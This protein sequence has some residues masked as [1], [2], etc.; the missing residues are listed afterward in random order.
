MKVLGTQFTPNASRKERDVRQNIRPS[1]REFVRTGAAGAALML[2][3]AKLAAA[4]SGKLPQRSFGKTGV[5]VSI[6]GLGT[7]SLGNLSEKKDAEALLNK[8]IDL[9]INYIDT[10]PSATS[11]ATFTGYGKAQRY[12][13]SILKE[14]RAEVFVV[15]KC[16]ETERDKALELLK[17]SLKELG[18]E[19]ADLVHSHSIGHA[20]Y[21][22]DALVGD[23]GTMA[24]LEQARKDGLTRF[25]GI[26]GHNRPEKF[27]KVLEKRKIDGMMNAINIVDRH[28][29][30]FE[31]VV[32]PT[33]RKQQ[34]A[35]AAM[36]VYG[37]G[38]VA[39]KMPEELRRA[40]L[41][42]ALGVEGVAVAVLGMRTIQE[43]EQN[44]EWAKSFEPLKRAELADLKKKTVEL[45]KQ[46]GAH[47]DRLDSNGEKTRPLVNA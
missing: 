8:A 30:A 5:K 46:W 10:A 28:T 32:W 17:K 6:I 14:R 15:T 43:L 37:G 44:V 9:G 38:I 41:R 36:K 34:V 12:L 45:A 39:C 29:Y 7:V 19:R 31:D 13:N 33:A 20:V 16:L 2:G 47:L 35:L 3:G 4:E 40:S 25:V 1:R 24:A 23:N 21:D 27:V 42:F 18:I 22:L 11:R 26:T